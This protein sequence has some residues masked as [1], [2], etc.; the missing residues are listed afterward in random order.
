MGRLI[1]LNLNKIKIIKYK[2]FKTSNLFRIDPLMSRVNGL[3]GGESYFREAEPYEADV[4]SARLH[5]R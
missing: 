1:F 5:Q 3:M 4:Y 2:E